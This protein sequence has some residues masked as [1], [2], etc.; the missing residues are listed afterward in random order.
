[1][2][3]ASDTISIRP[4]IYDRLGNSAV[5]P[6]G[7]L[8]IPHRLPSGETQLLG[9]TQTSKAGST[10]YDIRHDATTAGEHAVHVLLNGAPI[11]GSPVTFVVLP[12]KPD[13]AWCKLLSPE[14]ATL[15]TDRSYTFTLKT[16]DRFGNECRVGGLTL[17]TRLSLVKQNARDQT[18]LVPANHSNS[19]ED[20]SDGTY[21]IHITLNI[22]CTVRLILNIDKNLQAGSGEL[23]PLALT[24]ADGNANVANEDR[25]AKLTRRN[26]TKRLSV[27]DAKSKELDGNEPADNTEEGRRLS[28]ELAELTADNF[29]V[30][31][32][33]GDSQNAVRHAVSVRKRSNSEELY[34][35]RSLGDKKPGEPISLADDVPSFN[36]WL[37]GLVAGNETIADTIGVGPVATGEPDRDAAV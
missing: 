15:W 29:Y 22:A 13:A 33:D 24:F 28:A 14:E 5:L 10:T 30:P 11:Q 36:N 17:S 18:S 3:H 25:P 1:V 6:E 21:A 31:P 23:P 16:F 2:L 8:S 20:N 4:M 34:G 35:D 19:W 9:Y 12:S 7:V 27:G 32:R 37:Y 26:S